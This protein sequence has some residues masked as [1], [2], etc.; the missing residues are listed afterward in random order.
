MHQD[1]TGS[2]ADLRQA[3]SS[4]SRPRWP[5]VRCSKGRNRPQTSRAGSRLPNRCELNRA[6][7]A[8]SRLLMVV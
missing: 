3:L 6:S 1:G 8:L 4:Y 5:C 2:D 7:Q